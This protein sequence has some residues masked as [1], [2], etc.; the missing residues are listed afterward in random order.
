MLLKN[1]K[2]YKGLKRELKSISLIN[3]KFLRVDL[4]PNFYIKK[5]YPSAGFL[6]DNRVVFN[7]K[8]NTYRLIIKINYDYPMIWFDLLGHMPN[9]IQLTQVK[10]VGNDQTVA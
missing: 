7:I 9:T 2:A 10:F 8:G 1:K 4:T 6:A 3:I 5:E